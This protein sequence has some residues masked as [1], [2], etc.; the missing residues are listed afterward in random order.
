MVEVLADIT[1]FSIEVPA[2][3]FR[4]SL[5]A[6]RR[7]KASKLEDFGR[8][9]KYKHLSR[10]LHEAIATAIT[11]SATGQINLLFVSSDVVMA[12]SHGRHIER[13]RSF[14]IH[15]FE[16]IRSSSSPSEILWL[17]DNIR[18][19]SKNS[20]LGWMNP[21]FDITSS[22]RSDHH[23]GEWHLCRFVMVVHRSFSGF[24]SQTAL[25]EKSKLI[26]SWWWSA[27]ITDRSTFLHKN[28]NQIRNQ[29]QRF[30]EKKLMQCLASMNPWTIFFPNVSVAPIFGSKY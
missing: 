23:T 30:R 4:I 18:F 21:P 12:A 10:E 20:R 1:S 5:S 24:L 17:T 2:N 15:A 9:C 14:V 28:F 6:H 27:E 3:K 13:A 25:G 8:L 11:R 16:G 19:A 7:G 22:F 29:W 26:T